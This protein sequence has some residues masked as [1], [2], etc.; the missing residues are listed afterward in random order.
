MA[1]AEKGASEYPILGWG[2]RGWRV[3]GPGS[4]NG[5]LIFVSVHSGSSCWP[6]S[7]LI[8]DSGWTHFGLTLDS[9]KAF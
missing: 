9:F 5:D 7:G 8:L 1:E 2:M 4:P 3:P 6:H